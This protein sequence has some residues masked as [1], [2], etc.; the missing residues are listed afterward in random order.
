VQLLFVTYALLFLPAW[1]ALSLQSTGRARPSGVYAASFAALSLVFAIP[2]FAIA[3]YRLT[4]EGAA[5]Y[6]GSSMLHFIARDT[7]SL[8]HFD[9]SMGLD[10]VETQAFRAWLNLGFAVI[11]LAELASPWVHLRRSWCVL[12]LALIGPFHLLS[13]LLMHVAFFHNLVLLVVLYVV[14]LCWRGR[15]QPAAAAV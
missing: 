9:F 13:P 4:H 6:F 8:D 10:L 5:L 7:L 11:T 3:I 14:P 15:S 1:D 2:Y 12:W